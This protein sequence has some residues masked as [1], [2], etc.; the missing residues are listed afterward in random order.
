MFHMDIGIPRTQ[1]LEA[2]DD[3]W[4]GI[5]RREEGEH[6]V[7]IIDVSTLLVSSFSRFIRCG[8]G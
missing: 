3:L 1:D 6:S 7:P 2:V 4:K 8:A 5:K